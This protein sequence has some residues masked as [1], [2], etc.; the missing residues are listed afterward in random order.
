MPKDMH[1]HVKQYEKKEKT[2]ET[3]KKSIEKYATG[4]HN[5]R[6]EDFTT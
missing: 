5:P 1:K 4:N 3:D 2:I 6:I